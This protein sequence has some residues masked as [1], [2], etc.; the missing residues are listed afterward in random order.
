MFIK[1]DKLGRI[2]EIKFKYQDPDVT[3]EIL[4]PTLNMFRGRQLK[5]SLKECIEY[6]K[7]SILAQKGSV[8]AQ[9][10]LDRIH[11]EW[12]QPKTELTSFNLVE[13]V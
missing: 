9:K 4:K 13:E 11:K 7:I 1:K 10:E 5:T 8:E 3:P 12:N 2:C 6:A